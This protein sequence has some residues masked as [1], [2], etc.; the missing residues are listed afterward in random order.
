MA[1]PKVSEQRYP[2]ALSGV[3]ILELSRLLPGALA[4]QMIAD[5]GAE[6]IKVEQPGIGDYQRAFPPIG[7]RESGSFMLCNRNKR[8]ITVDLKSPRGKEIV[9]RLART[10]DV[11][12]EGFRPGVMER[13]GLGYGPLARQN[14][15]L[16]YCS[17]SSYGQDG[18]YRLMPGHDMNYLG[19]V[20]MMQLFSRPGTGPFVP[21][22]LIADLGGGTLMAVFGILAAL[23]ARGSTGKGQYVDVS[24]TDGMMAFMTSH[25]AEWLFAQ[26]EPAGGEYFNTGGAAAY[27]VYRGADGRW[28]TL[29]II[30]RHFWERLRTVLGRSD[31]PDDPLA[32]GAEGERARAILTSVFASRPAMEWVVLLR[33]NDLPVGPI[34]TLQEAFADPQMRSRDMLQWIDHPV[35]GR[36]PQ[37]GFP[38]K[39]SDTP[40]AIRRPPP[41]L[42]EHTDEV[43]AEIGYDADAIAQ[44]RAEKA[45]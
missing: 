17:L 29:G 11:L 13:L 9:R 36:I 42:G 3:T 5:L 32:D 4:T 8:S 19:T 40:G 24:M 44:L 1:E 12:I 34:N 39:F 16:V 6:V 10:A 33:E 23:F 35:E 43:L 26:R 38:V 21:G 25:A 45:V 37:I 18:P 14:E 28:F 7:V 15:Q 22:P 30:E 2:G 27:N 41:M 31:L 20:G